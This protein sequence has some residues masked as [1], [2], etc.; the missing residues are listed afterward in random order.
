MTQHIEIVGGGLAGLSLGIGLRR[1]GA[2]V[3]LHEASSYP[4]HRV[5]GEFIAGAAIND[6]EQLGIAGE[7]TSA[8]SL[9]TT[10]WSHFSNVVYQRKLPCVAYGVSRYLLDAQLAEKFTN[11]GGELRTGSRMT[12]SQLRAGVVWAQGRQRS[13]SQ[14][15]GLKMHCL[16][17][18]SQADLEVHLGRHGYVGVASVENGRVNV[19][20]LFRRRPVKADSREEQLP[21]Y[22][23]ACGLNELAQRVREGQPDRLSAVGVTALS[24]AEQAPD[25]AIRLG[26]QSG[27]IAPFTGNGMALALSSAALTLDPLT[28]FAHGRID[29]PTAVQQAN[30]RMTRRFRRRRQIAGMMHPW[31]LQP[32]RQKL[33]AL[34]ARSGLLP[35]ATL[36]RLTH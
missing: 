31:I 26:D 1:R 22:L 2:P 8:R 6:L 28:D 18:D 19:C 27:L 34:L 5:C 4:R 33:L 23:D 36:F 9:H 15:I 3:I 7:I 32:N 21:A 14:W 35:F 24:Y 20:G 17:M 11:A 29:W 30:A 12:D 25:Q 16:A 13:E 10:Q